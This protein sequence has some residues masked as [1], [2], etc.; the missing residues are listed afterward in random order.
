MSLDRL[1][2]VFGVLFILFGLS[3]GFIQDRGWQKLCGGIS[4]LSLGCFALAMAGDG[5]VKGEIRL[6]FSL[7]KRAAQP[8]LFWAAITLVFT[9]GVGVLVTAGWAIFYKTW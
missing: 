9:A 6:Q 7:I 5:L 1:M 2:W 4:V 3:L 8:R